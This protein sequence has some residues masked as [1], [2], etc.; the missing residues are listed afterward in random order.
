MI[1]NVEIKNR[2]ATY[3]PSNEKFVCGNSGDLVKFTFDEEWAEH[4]N[5][6]ARFIW[7]NKY[8]DVEFTGD[9]CE[10]PVISGA[11]AFAVGVYAG[12]LADGEPIISS[13]QATI[14]ATLSIRC[15]ARTPNAG[16]GENY[17]NEAKGAAI[18]AREAADEAKEYAEKSKAKD[19]ADIEAHQAYYD[20]MKMCKPSGVFIVPEDVRES[21]SI[22]GFSD[23]ETATGIVFPNGFRSFT[24]FGGSPNDNQITEI[25]HLPLSCTI[26]GSGLFAGFPLELFK[27]PRKVTE[28]PAY[29][30]EYISSDH[31]TIDMTAFG[32]GETFPT[33]QDSYITDSS[34]TIKVC[35]GRKAELA[36][37]T[38]WSAYANRI[39]E[40]EV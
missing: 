18:E 6:T 28:I 32:E 15:V 11:T 34:V 33:L 14:S 9:T 8:Y 19:Y 24:Y 5:K 17:T 37:M 27:I 25:T 13:T 1:L 31:V 26:L 10:V 21:D 39:V 29:F 38:N 22:V 40:G 36:S 20:A 2:V 16:T 12:E 7:G 35:K 3:K 30:L 4:E 23:M